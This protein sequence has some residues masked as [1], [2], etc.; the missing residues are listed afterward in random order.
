MRMLEMDKFPNNRNS[1]VDN[2]RRKLTIYMFLKN[3]SR[4]MQPM[5]DQAKLGHQQPAVVAFRNCQEVMASRIH[6]MVQG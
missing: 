1:K 2:R 3:G 6:L 4:W 5:Q